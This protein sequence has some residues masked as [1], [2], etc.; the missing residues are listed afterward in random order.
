MHLNGIEP[1]G[2][3]DGEN[4][5]CRPV[6]IEKAGVRCGFLGYSFEREQY[7]S[8]A[9]KY[10]RANVGEICEQ[11]SKLRE[12]VDYV[13]AS[14]HWGKE[15]MQEPS[16]TAIAAARTLIDSGCDVILGHHP[17]VLQ[18][19]ERYGRGVILYSLGNFVFDKAWWPV[20]KKSCITTI[21]LPRDPSLDIKI[22]VTPILIN[23]QYQPVIV[24]GAVRSRH[25]RNWEKLCA[26]VEHCVGGNDRLY[27]LQQKSILSIMAFTKI[28]HILKN[29]SRYDRGVFV[30]LL[31]HKI[32]RLPARPMSSF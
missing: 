24:T 6:V 27:S 21:S 25:E 32:L 5:R 10:A 23:D 7:F 30:H 17:H 2:L 8:G 22:E 29:S 14:L 16:A 11:V 18:G 1:L 28:I 20:C 12:N 4:N 9:I 31:K 15:Y 26:R 19:M 3:A 13:I